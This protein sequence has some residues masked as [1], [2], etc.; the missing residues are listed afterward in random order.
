MDCRQGVDDADRAFIV[1]RHVLWG[2]WME[3]SLRPAPYRVAHLHLP[4][5]YFMTRSVPVQRLRVFSFARVGELFNDHG[6]PQ[7]YLRILRGEQPYAGRWARIQVKMDASPYRHAAELPVG[8]DAVRYVLSYPDLIEAE[9]D[10]YE[11]YLCY[12]AKEGRAW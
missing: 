9:V 12:G 3:L 11:H 4:D 5:D 10:P 2:R 7:V 1:P 8:F 6:A